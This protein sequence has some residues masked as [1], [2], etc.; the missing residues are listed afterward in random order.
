MV[1]LNNAASSFPKPPEV[2][3]AVG[4][5]LATEP[6]H[7]GRAGFERQAEDMVWA[8]RQGLADLFGVEDPTHIVLTSGATESL[9]LALFGSDLRGHVVT[10]AIEHNSV[11][12]PLNRLKEQRG[13][14]LTVVAC[15]DNGRVPP[16]A[17]EQAIRPDTCALVVN[18]S[19]NVTGTVQDLQALGR[20]AQQHSVLFVVDASQ[21]AG[22]VPIDV[23]SG[24][25]DLLAFA[26]HKSLWGIPGIGGLYVREALSLDPLIVG[27]TGIRSD[28]LRQPREMPM[29]YEAGTQNMLGI[30]ALHAGVDFVLQHGVEDIGQR[31]REHVERLVAELE[32]IPGV[33]LHAR[34]AALEYGGMLS[35]NIEGVSPEDAGYMF[36]SCFGITVRTGLHCAP[37]IHEAL[38]SFPHG[39]IRVSPSYFTTDEDIDHLV[40]AVHAVADVECTV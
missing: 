34:D 6:F 38:G 16:S 39:S 35:F 12:R 27:G 5:Y 37:L 3:E 9:N 8:C 2:N 32:P 25:I 40:D 28:L 30:A 11:L 36:E 33:G 15:D 23:E 10:T 13:V 7:A 1:Y 24:H 4:S 19:S 17:I 31:R 26:G 29:Y 20:I 14:E 18:H 21:S 22:V